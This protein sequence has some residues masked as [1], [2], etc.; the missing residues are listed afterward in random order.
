MWFLDARVDA[1]KVWFPVVWEDI[2]EASNV[3]DYNLREE[4]TKDTFAVDNANNQTT[5]GMANVIPWINAPKL[6]AS[7]SII[8]RWSLLAS[9]AEYWI[10]TSPW[11]SMT[12]YDLESLSSPWW[13][14]TEES[15]DVYVSSWTYL[16]I[17]N[18]YVWNSNVTSTILNIRLY[19]SGGYVGH[20]ARWEWA[21]YTTGS[22]LRTFN[23]WEYVR[24]YVQ[25]NY[26]TL[27]SDIKIDFMKL[28]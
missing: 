2:K 28:A 27:N 20:I 12:K 16:I 3:I 22:I 10:S 25:L 9:T 5:T 15:W 8:G 21:I 24:L 13:D 17:G 26:S 11:T 1:E 18:A 4:Q 23:A 7:T 6:L 14:L 19:N